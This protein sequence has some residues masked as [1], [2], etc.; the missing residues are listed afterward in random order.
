ML[1]SLEWLRILNDTSIFVSF[2]W[3]VYIE[4]V[5]MLRYWTLNIQLLVSASITF[6]RRITRLL[7]FV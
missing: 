4:C 1:C 7:F 5:T 2:A 6:L 3:H